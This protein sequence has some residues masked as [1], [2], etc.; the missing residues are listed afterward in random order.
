MCCSVAINGLRK[1]W[2]ALPTR[3]FSR[4]AVLSLSLRERNRDFV[5]EK[6]ASKSCSPNG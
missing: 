5:T 4:K 2:F 1:V 3:K 6:S